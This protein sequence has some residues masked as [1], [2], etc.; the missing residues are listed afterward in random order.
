VIILLD[1]S[2]SMDGGKLQAAKDGVCELLKPLKDCDRVMVITFNGEVKKLTPRPVMPSQ[3][4][5]SGVQASGST[6]LYDAILAV[7]FKRDQPRRPLLVVLTDGADTSG[8]SPDLA[9][10]KLSEPG[11]SNFQCLLLGVGR[12]AGRALADLA[13]AK[14]P[15]VRV[16]TVENSQ[17]GIKL[18]FT[19]ASDLLSAL[20]IRVEVRS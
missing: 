2:G 3:V 11:V 19:K 12:L 18:A 9:R 16:E 6:S 17:A 7:E 10:G 5:V 4:D 8:K 20:L 15:N 1:I 13:P 14:K